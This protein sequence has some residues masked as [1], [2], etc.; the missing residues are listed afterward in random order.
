MATTPSRLPLH[1]KTTICNCDF[2]TIQFGVPHLPP[3]IHHD[4]IP[5]SFVNI[6]SPPN[7]IRIM[8][9]IKMQAPKARNK[10]THAHRVILLLLIYKL[11]KFICLFK[12]YRCSQHII[13]SL[14][15]TSEEKMKSSQLRRGPTTL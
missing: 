14:I 4:S 9:T 10:G 7:V 2:N 8:S 5:I 11:S 6:P 3:Q 15:S 12:N 13:T 1:R